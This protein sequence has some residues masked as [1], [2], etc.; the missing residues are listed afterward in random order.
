MPKH[1]HDLEAKK[2]PADPGGIPQPAVASL[3]RFYKTAGPEA[4]IGDIADR[5]EIILRELGAVVRQGGGFIG[6]IKAFLSFTEGGSISMS[7]VKEKVEHLPFD[8]LAENGASGFK[9]AVTAIVYKFT[10]AELSRLLNLALAVGLPESVCRPVQV[11]T[12]NLKP[13]APF[14]C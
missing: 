1:D 10:N 11:E 14:G 4:R 8:H 13:I 12:Q 2:S 3:S 5:L 9:L 6:H 7:V